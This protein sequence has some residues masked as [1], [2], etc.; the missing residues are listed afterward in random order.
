MKS[1]IILIFAVTAATVGCTSHARPGTAQALAEGAGADYA[2]LYRKAPIVCEGAE[3]FGSDTAFNCDREACFQAAH[4][5]AEA[6]CPANCQRFHECD[7]PKVCTGSPKTCKAPEVLEFK[8]AMC[9]SGTG[10]FC[11]GIC[12]C[13][14]RC[15]QDASLPLVD[16][17]A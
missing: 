14:C 3:I 13:S 5:R 15:V 2:L 6:K 8:T 10:Y 17:D 1:T 12:T 4:D 7:D 9:P 16:G 11:V